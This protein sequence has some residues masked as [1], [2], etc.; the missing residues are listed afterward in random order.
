VTQL[1]VVG[2]RSGAPRLALFE[3]WDS[4]S[5]NHPSGAPIIR[6]FRMS[7]TARRNM[8]SS[9]ATPDNSPLPIPLLGCQQTV[10]AADCDM[11]RKRHEPPQEAEADSHALQ[12][13]EKIKLV[14]KCPG[15]DTSACADHHR[16]STQHLHTGENPCRAR[17]NTRRNRTARFVNN[18]LGIQTAGS[19]VVHCTL[20]DYHAEDRVLD[21]AYAEFGKAH[22][23]TCPDKAPRPSTWRYD[24]EA[25][26][27]EAEKYGGFVWRFIGTPFG[28][29]Y[30]DED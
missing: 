26:R 17:S 13:G 5:I 1:S 4:V 8:L 16:R 6:G 22:C 9:A 25:R 2:C 14:P 21:R 28:L 24:D 27:T 18:A 29:R 7:G 11:S 3:T 30:T 10:P 12:G 23:D 15:H 20:Y 19:K